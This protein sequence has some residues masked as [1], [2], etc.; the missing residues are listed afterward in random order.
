MAK[1]RFQVIE[2]ASGYAV[3]DRITGKEHWMSDGV[4]AVFTPSGRPMSPGTE[5]FRRAW[6]RALN[7]C[8]AD[9]AEAY[10]FDEED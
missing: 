6:Q 1:H 3:C 9:T 7:A 2:Y 4:D 8:A 5:R 10:G